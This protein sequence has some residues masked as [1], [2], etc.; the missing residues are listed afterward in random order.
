MTR[1]VGSIN[2]GLRPLAASLALVVIA[3]TGAACGGDDESSAPTTGEDQAAPTTSEGSSTTPATNENAGSAMNDIQE[4]EV[5]NGV[6]TASGV[7]ENIGDEAASYKLT[8]AFTDDATGEE[9]GTKVAETDVVE[10]GGSG[11]WSITI[12]G[13]PDAEVTCATKSLVVMAAE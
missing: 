1:C 5:V 13:L 10:P 6:G 2:I 3:G 9:L 11:E 4:C 7:A 8:L 12:D